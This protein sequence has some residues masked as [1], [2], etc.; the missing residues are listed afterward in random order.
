MIEPIATCLKH[1]GVSLNANALAHT[2]QVKDFL[3]FAEGNHTNPPFIRFLKL[4][5][6]KVHTAV[7]LALMAGLAL[8]QT[9]ATFA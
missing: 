9:L 8:P 3:A 6:I 4:H 1:V 7:G 5:G 2:V